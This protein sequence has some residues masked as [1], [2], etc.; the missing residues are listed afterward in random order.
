M[1]LIKQEKQ[2]RE[3][4]GTGSMT[5]TIFAMKNATLE[6]LKAEAKAMGFSLEEAKKGNDTK[7]TKL[8]MLKEEIS[9]VQDAYKRYEKLGLWLLGRQRLSLR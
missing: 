3:S 7:K 4:R 2:L 9:L 8:N 1:E 5:D 6:Q